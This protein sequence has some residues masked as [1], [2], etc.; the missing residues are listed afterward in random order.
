MTFVIGLVVLFL[1]VL[2][3]HPEPPLL[4]P[5][6]SAPAITLD[7]AAGQ[8]ETVVGGGVHHPVVAAFIET[9]CVTCQ[10]QAPALCRVASSFPRASVVLVDSGEDPQ[11]ALLSFTSR[12]LPAGCDATLYADP[13]LDV[14]KAYQVRVVPTVYVIDASGTITYGGLGGTG[15]AGLD[16]ALQRLS[17]AR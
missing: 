8:R 4:A 17:G 13:G 6:S 11:N 5:G 10:Q 1:L 16:G 14:S 7:S 9:A 3:V 2:L 15:V 12:Y